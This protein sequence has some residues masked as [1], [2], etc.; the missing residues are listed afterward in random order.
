QRLVRNP[1]YSRQPFTLAHE[2]AHGLYHYDRP[3]ILCRAND[4]RQL[5]QFA[6]RFASHFLIPYEA[7]HER[8]RQLGIKSVTSPEELVHL[9]RYFRVSFGA[10]K[11]RLEWERRLNANSSMLDEVKPVK[12]A[13]TLGYRPLRYEFGARPWPPEERL[14]RIFLELVNRALQQE[15]I[16]LRRAA[17]MLCI[18]D[19]EME[20]RLNFTDAVIG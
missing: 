18:S 9:A 7:L 10:M 5:E 8:L 16:S 19:I 20:E 17:E 12:L 4:F 11:R 13:L 14:P 1:G 2:L 6:E 15:K 3:S